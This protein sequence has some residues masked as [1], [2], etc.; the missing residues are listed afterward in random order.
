MILD[1]PERWKIIEEDVRS[2]LMPRFPYA[3]YYRA[4]SDRVQ[5]LLSNITVDILITGVIVLPTK[6]LL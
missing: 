1:S 3:V 5:F 6:K 2:Y 4:F